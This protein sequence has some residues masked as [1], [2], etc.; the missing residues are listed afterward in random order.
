MALKGNPFI[1]VAEPSVDVGDYF[2]S[3]SDLYRV[4]QLGSG[5]V[6]V[7]DCRSGSLIDMP[8]TELVALDR[9]LR[10]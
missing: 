7:E 8:L 6:L 5:Y 9:V 2:A 3:D 10:E 1:P 4:E